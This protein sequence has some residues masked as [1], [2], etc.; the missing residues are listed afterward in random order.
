MKQIIAVLFSWLLA[1]PL[2][3]EHTTTA[4]GYKITKEW[5]IEPNTDFE[6]VAKYQNYK[7]EIWDKETVRIEFVMDATSGKMNE[8]D[9][10]NG[11]KINVEKSDR[12]LKV[13]TNMNERSS[14]IWSWIFNNNKNNDAYKISNTLY[15]PKSIASLM[16]TINYCELIIDDI[17]IPTKI[18]CNYGEVSIQ[19]NK[20]RTIL[21]T[22][23]SDVKIGDISHLKISSSYSDYI[24]SIIDT[25]TIAS[26]YDDIKLSSCSI[27]PSINM[28]YGNIT[29]GKIGYIKATTTYSDIK[30]NLITQE[31]NATLT[32][33]ELI[34]NNVSRN[35]SG[36]GINSV[37]SDCKIK[38]N[39]ENPI[40]L[41]VND[42]NGDINIKNSPLVITKKQETSKTTLLHAKTKSA[43]ESSPIIK[44]N[45]KF[46][47]LI[48]N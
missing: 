34:L 24:L 46:S 30:I 12:K 37:Y 42:V 20:N 32:Y 40:N 47:D 7:V 11:L 9:F 6:L 38:I 4:T 18:N 13:T 17:N 3:A 48:F 2:L 35:I 43:T 39:P 16:F 27:L 10:K 22:S 41:V 5:N 29:I 21:N 33:S 14:S 31:V 36:I 23:Y 45:S 25:L 26:S 8:D 19:K 28:S 44:I 15:L 1:L